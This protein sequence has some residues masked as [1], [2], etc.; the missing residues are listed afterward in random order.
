MN[1]IR[2]AAVA[3]LVLA[4]GIVSESRETRAREAKAQYQQ[5]GR[6]NSI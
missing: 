1:A 4:F 3:L 6:L 2:F 5:M